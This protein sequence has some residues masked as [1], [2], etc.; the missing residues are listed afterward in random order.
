MSS[1]IRER[2]LRWRMEATGPAYP[3]EIQAVQRSAS[4]CRRGVVRDVGLSLRT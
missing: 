3:P 1:A 4:I 2:S